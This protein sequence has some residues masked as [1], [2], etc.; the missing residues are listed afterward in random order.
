MAFLRTGNA[1][2]PT[3]R[4][5]RRTGTKDFERGVRLTLRI[6][7]Y[8]SNR[9]TKDFI[10]EQ[11][12]LMAPEVRRKSGAWYRLNRQDAAIREDPYPLLLQLRR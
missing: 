9:E 12:R 2:L 8:T 5:L 7:H 1:A 11:A 3:K 4:A 10:I 6:E